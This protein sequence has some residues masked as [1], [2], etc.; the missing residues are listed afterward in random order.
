[1]K[2]VKVIIVG[3][4]PAGASCAKLLVKAG[5]SCLVLD[6]STFPRPK[7]C[8]GWVTPNVFRQ[9]NTRPEDYPYSLTTFPYLKITLGRW[10]IIYPGKQYAIRR[11]EFD[12][13]MIRSSGV[14]L[15]QHEANVIKRGGNG[16]IV[17][18]LYSAE[19]LVGAGGTSCPVRRTFF[20]DQVQK[21]SQI[22]S[23]EEEYKEDW[24]DPLC[25]L[26]FFDEGLPGY[27]WY[28]PKEG[29]YLNIGLGANAAALRSRNI[30]VK[31]YWRRHVSRL[32]QTGLIKERAFRPEGYTYYLQSPDQKISTEK[33]YL[34]GDSLG[35]ATL[36]M[37]EGIGPAVY[38]GQEAA[39]SMIAERPYRLED[40]NECSL[41]PGGLY[42]LMM[43]LMN[44]N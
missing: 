20:R 37:G 43:T 7:L 41:L 32:V 36:D 3:G 11:V 26:W 27:A 30:S 33:I 42:R 2:S 23:L 21:G 22:V 1:M 34:V 39:R 17:D 24:H 8:A 14:E 19:Y 35:L 16:Y 38:S 28:V 40:L 9:L 13:W 44:R 12:E 6:K 25:R 4:G 29:G 15:V 18:D 5:I 10:P 31:E